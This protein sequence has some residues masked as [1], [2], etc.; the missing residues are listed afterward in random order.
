M[1]H[2]PNRRTSVQVTLG[3]IDKALA[4]AAVADGEAIALNS[5][6][7][8]CLVQSPSR[9]AKLLQDPAFELR[10]DI[11]EVLREA[12]A[13]PVAAAQAV[14]IDQTESRESEAR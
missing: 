7:T 12:G 13:S 5:K 11:A 10:A 1:T 6:G 9:L 14:R 2:H 8:I 3:R 4:D